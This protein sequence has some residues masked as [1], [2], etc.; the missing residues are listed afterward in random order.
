MRL[1]SAAAQAERGV[2][3][4]AGSSGTRLRPSSYLPCVLHHGKGTTGGAGGV[5]RDVPCSC[6]RLRAPAGQARGRHRADHD[7]PPGAPQRPFGGPPARAARRVRGRG[8]VGGH[9][10]RARRRGQGVLGGPRLRRRRRA[11]P[12]RGPRPAAPVHLAHAHHPG[13]AAGGDRPRAGPRHGRGVPA[14]GDLR[15][16]GGRGVGELRAARRQ[17]G[18]VLPHARGAGGAQRRAEAADGARAHRRPGGRASRP[19]SGA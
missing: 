5:P 9:R 17:G 1:A 8:P 10:H 18:L 11:R 13:R 15:P 16:R 7:E 2:R 6:D 3:T 19:R 12:G 4:W 14:G